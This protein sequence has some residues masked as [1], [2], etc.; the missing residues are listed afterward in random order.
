MAS[1]ATLAKKPKPAAKLP[2]LTFKEVDSERFA[3]L[4]RLFES[5]GGPKYCWCMAWRRAA[6]GG[7]PTNNAAR[8]RAL[9]LYVDNGTPIGILGYAD[10]EPVAW[11]SIAPRES[12]HNIADVEDEEQEEPRAKVWSLACFFIKRQYRSQGVMPKIIAAAIACAK[13]HRA[14]VIEAYPVDPSSPS[15]RFMGYVSTFKRM[16][17]SHVGRAGTR[18]HVYRLALKRKAKRAH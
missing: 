16:G 12:Y 6:D 7:R 5:K 9:K 8:K 3:D 2:R 13:R 18:R 1:R 14:Q 17:F 15:Y 4:A 10:D 11:C